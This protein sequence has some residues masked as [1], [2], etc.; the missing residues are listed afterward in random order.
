MTSIAFI[1]AGSVE[2]TRDLLA[3]LLSFDDLADVESGCTTSTPSG[4]RPRRASRSQ[5]ASQLG[6]TP[7]VSVHPDRAT[8]FDG[9]DFVVNMIQVGGL[10]ATK[11]DFEVPDQHGIRQTI[12]DTLGIGGIFR[13]LRTFPVLERHRRRHARGLPGRLACSTTPTRWR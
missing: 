12:A 5:V 10:A 2:F 7:K 1:G 8:A 9:A 6:A 13:A 3:D 4:W 11:I